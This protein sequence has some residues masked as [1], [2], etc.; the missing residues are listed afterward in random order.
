MGR[1]SSG[2]AR[3]LSGKVLWAGQKEAAGHAVGGI[4]TLS[5][6]DAGKDNAG[7]S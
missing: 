5:L 3:I 7:V 6:R 1:V 2:E 4:G